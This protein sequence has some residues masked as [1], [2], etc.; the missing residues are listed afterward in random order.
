MPRT[1]TH[2]RRPARR[3][4]AAAGL[5]V[6]AFLTA[7]GSTEEDAEAGSDGGPSPIA[8]QRSSG[9][10]F[11]AVVLADQL[12]YF[13][14]E[15][16]D[17]TIDPSAG[18]PTAA[19]PLLLNDE[20]QFAM[21]DSASACRAAAEDL[22][23]VVVAGILS[24]LPENPQQD[25]VLVPPGSPI[26]S[27]DDLDGTTIGVPS[28][29]GSIQVTANAAI[30]A[31]GGD[32]T[33]VEYVQ[34]PFDTLA[35]AAES[36]QVDAIITLANFYAA[37]QQ[38]GFSPVTDGAAQLPGAPTVV[39][40]ASARYVAENPD[41]VEA[42][43]AATVRGNDHAN[44]AP[45]DVRAVDTELTQLPADYIADREIARFTSE[46]DVDALGD[47]CGAMADQGFIEST[48]DAEDMVWADAP[49]T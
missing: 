33:S 34:L 31:A 40:A 48:P 44:E 2:R 24:A 18:N 45:D 16:L 11:E 43:V 6:G 41:V 29:G 36:G 8:V 4:A 22:P 15:G 46:V 35:T 5:A 42:F 39:W 19:I 17:A 25:G 23:I 20:Y 13:E 3:R 28:L 38:A 7:C 49:R 10:S 21:I 12:G 14:D 1:P 37:A 26:D 9:G 47:L 32:P 27:A 30:E